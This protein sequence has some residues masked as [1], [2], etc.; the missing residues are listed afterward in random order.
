MT[1]KAGSINQ[2]F[3]IEMTTAIAENDKKSMQK[4]L[5]V[6]STKNDATI[7][8]CLFEISTAQDTS[9]Y[10]MLGLLLND[11][12]LPPGF[13]SE[14]TELV[15]D[16]AMV[17]PHFAILFIENTDLK[18]QK[19]AVPVFANI[20]VSET[21]T[22]ILFEVLKAI[23]NTRDKSCID[24]V[25]DFIFY[26]NDEL[27]TAAV[28]ALEKIGGASVIKRLAFA[29]T[30]SKSDQQI[31]D[32]MDRLGKTLTMD[33]SDLIEEVSQFAAKS[34]TLEHLD[35]DSDMAQLIKMLNSP[36]PHE[37][38][39]AIDL[40]IETGVKAIPAV[41]GN[42][43]SDD[44]DSI[45]NALD[46]LGTINNEAALPPVMKIFNKNHPDSNVRFAAFEAIAKLPETDSI[47]SIIKGIEDKVE[48]VRIAA[49]SAMNKNLS[50]ILTSGILSKIETFG[51]KS[52]QK[53]II[54][55]IIDSF[56]GKIF[57]SLLGSDSFVFIASEYLER[58]NEKTRKYFVDLLKKRGTKT[59]A[60]NI[61]ENASRIPPKK[62]LLVYLVDDS[63]IM[64]NV[65]IKFFHQMG[66]V[67]KVFA[68]PAD[69]LKAIKRKKPD[70]VISDLN[71]LNMNGL[72]LTGKIREKYNS[73]E[74]P[75][76]IITT[77]Q[78][79]VEE[80]KA[81]GSIMPDG[82]LATDKEL[83]MVLPKPPVVAKLKPLFSIILANK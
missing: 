37:R 1:K 82:T 61:Q 25:A 5:P 9:A 21:D 40:L 76:I 66:H 14:I 51:Q 44:P 17:N 47:T 58:A 31:L 78:D 75:V 70:L 27:K 57:S 11:K 74:L 43:K 13:K 71:M 2:N 4:I 10:F 38:H 26:D 20:L 41:S 69:A 18:T 16:K 73:K 65:Y 54:A 23:G 19:A 34:D 24:V 50:E 35:N 46:I 53:A 30:T 32:V 64:L 60:R 62:G 77:Q 33:T 81:T 63:E 39:T 80:H 29:S 67:P 59:L 56:S 72:Q 79:F 8:R 28:N 55:A 7:H 42:I 15:L 12:T 68:D 52:N 22:H 3:I 48:Q 45:V 36:S 49:A 6:M 83:N